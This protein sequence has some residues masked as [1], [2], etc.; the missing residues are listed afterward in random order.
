MYLNSIGSMT[1]SP[2][3]GMPFYAAP[4]LSRF[5]LMTVCGE[6]FTVTAKSRQLDVN[7]GRP[8]LENDLESEN[9]ACAK[10]KAGDVDYFLRLDVDEGL[11]FKISGINDR[12][13]IISKCNFTYER[14]YLHINNMITRPE[15]RGMGLNSS[16]QRLAYLL[17]GSP[18]HIRIYSIIDTNPN[19]EIIRNAF[20][21]HKTGSAFFDGTI[22]E[23][24]KNRFGILIEG[25]RIL[26]AKAPTYVE[27]STRTAS[28]HYIYDIEIASKTE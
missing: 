19:Y 26:S 17:A 25:I 3:S 1:F 12:G 27:R 10:L 18:R 23:S 6:D 20:Y 22:A 28:K 14:G 2:V 15:F 16:L 13:L 9:Y 21:A 7:I 4:A 24:V 11:T 5:N 8:P